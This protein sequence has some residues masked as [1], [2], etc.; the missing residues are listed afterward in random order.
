MLPVTKNGDYNTGKFLTVDVDTGEKWSR[1]HAITARNYS[2]TVRGQLVGEGWYI[3]GISELYR[4]FLKL[5]E[6]S[7]ELTY[8][9]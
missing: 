1:L 6:Y 7:Q 2:P 5:T 4:F 8:Y 3:K 9:F